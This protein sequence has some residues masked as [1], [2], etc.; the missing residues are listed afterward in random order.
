MRLPDKN[1]LA[2]GL[3]LALAACGGTGGNAAPVSTPTPP[4][5]PA[6]DYPMVIGAP[7]TVDGVLYTPADTLNFDE[8]GR[9]VLDEAG[10]TAV[11]GEHR[12]LPLPSYVEVTSLETGRTI[13]V[14]LERRGPMTGNSAVGLSAGALAQLGATPGTPVRVRRVN[15][16]EQE[17]A[18]LRRGERVPDRMDTP[19]SLVEVLR[20][21]LPAG[22]SA[23]VDAK[24]AHEAADASQ[25][26]ATRP[27]AEKGAQPA[28]KP[29]PKPKPEPK[30]KPKDTPPAKPAAP[31][32]TAP[33]PALP[34]EPKKPAAP[35]STQAAKP[36]KGTYAVQAGAFSVEANAK[37]V[38]SRIGGR[39]DKAG[40]FYVVR[41]GPFASRQEAEASLAKVKAAGYS[42]ARIYSVD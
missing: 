16:P 19:M 24:P 40:K 13:L 15:P 39:I 18:M 28:A 26:P 9:A 22:S 11:T 30:P 38:A 34:A 5:G 7:F 37:A 41:T 10:G 17:R 6:A 3:V 33:P 27:S 35:P 8:V 21:K 36:G 32:H 12:T 23:P 20:R 31:E 14:R 2:L 29:A 25:A 42:G 4:Q 1:F